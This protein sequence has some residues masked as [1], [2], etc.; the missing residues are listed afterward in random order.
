MLFD[1]DPALEV[2]PPVVDTLA[3]GWALWMYATAPAVALVTAAFS[4]AVAVLAVPLFDLTPLLV[5]LVAASTGPWR[6]A[7]RI[8]LNSSTVVAGVMVLEWAFTYSMLAI[9]RGSISTF[10]GVRA[11]SVLTTIWSIY[12]AQLVLL[13]L[14]FGF[15]AGASFIGI[16]K[17]G[18]QVAESVGASGGVAT[19]D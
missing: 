15:A 16:R 10:F 6:G 11:I 1:L 8:W 4:A 18:T 9:S 12:P 5:L 14:V 3:P 17:A 19:D 13:L 2:T 7:A